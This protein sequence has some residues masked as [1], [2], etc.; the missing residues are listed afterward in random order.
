MSAV[1]TTAAVTVE[2]VSKRFRVYH[3][4]NQS[5]KAAIMRG[6]RSVYEDFWALRDVGFEIPQATTF[7]LVG[8]NGS[9]KST[10]LKCIAGI[11]WPDSGTVSSQG[12]MAAL[13][14]VGSGFHPELSGRDN[15][16]LNGS[17]LGMT[18]KE[19]DRKFDGIVDFSGVEEFIDQPVKNYSSGMYVRLGF[20]VA[21]NVDPE[22]LLVDEVLAV[23]DAAFQEKC[24]EKFTQFRREGRTVVVVSHSMPSLRAM[25]DQVAWLEHGR[26]VD[27]GE[28]RPIL[29]RYLDSTRRDIRPGPNGS[30]RW[31]SGE[32]EI[33]GVEVLQD[34]RPVDAIHSGDAVTIRISYTAHEPVATPVFGLAL[35][36]PDGVHLWGSNTR[37]VSRVIDSI[38][39]SGTVD[40]TIPTA[41]LQPGAFEITAA[42]T[43]S[44][45]THVIDFVRGSARLNVVVGRAG[46]SD[47]VVALD[48]RWQ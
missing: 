7:G 19:I 13:L 30:I 24:A 23:G 35:D 27:T 5:L 36:T 12:R 44:S 45:T 18:R 21:I 46:D 4:R 3:E 39:G 37:D 40:C 34:G 26:L 15:V 1:T 43:D 17:I 33:D 32:A 2:S 47:G 11:L 42:I 25:C 48:G 28:A 38:A 6:R 9:G 16:Y 10:L 22:I 29:E 31:G 14:E 20:S 41:A 8:D